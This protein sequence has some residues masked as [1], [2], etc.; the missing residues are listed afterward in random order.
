LVAEVSLASNVKLSPS[1]IMLSGPAS[2]VGEIS[3]KIVV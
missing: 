2:A 1:Q 3:I